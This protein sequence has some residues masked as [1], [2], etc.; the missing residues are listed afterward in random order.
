[1]HGR[2]SVVIVAGLE[3]LSGDARLVIIATHDSPK[4]NGGPQDLH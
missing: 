1:M 4:A 3:F 2:A